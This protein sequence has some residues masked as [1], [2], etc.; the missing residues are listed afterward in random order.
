MNNF[1]FYSGHA[2]EESI[3]TLQF[4]TVHMYSYSSKFT[5]SEQGCWVFLFYL[6]CL[7]GWPRGKRKGN[8]EG[9][10]DDIIYKKVKILL[11]YRKNEENLCY[12]HRCWSLLRKY[13]FKHTGTNSLSMNGPFKIAN[14]RIGCL[15]KKKRNCLKVLET[16]YSPL[17]WMNAFQMIQQLARFMYLDGQYL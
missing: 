15:S 9:K 13:Y 7:W 12:V 11:N 1:T 10:E 5:K 8:V 14:V 16:T 17:P 3:Y 4:L 2:G 6:S